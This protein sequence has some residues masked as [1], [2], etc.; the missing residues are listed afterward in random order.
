MPSNAW[1]GGAPPTLLLRIYRRTDWHVHRCVRLSAP[2]A[3]RTRHEEALAKTCAALDVLYAVAPRQ[4][5][6]LPDAVHS[7][8]VASVV[9]AA[10]C[11]RRDLRAILIDQGFALAPG[12]TPEDLAS[13]IV[14]ELAHAR[15]ERAGFEYVTS[16]RARIERICILAER[17]FVARL[18]ASRTRERLERRII[19][20][21]STRA[22]YW[23]DAAFEARK[24]AWKAR[25]PVWR[26]A[27]LDMLS[28]LHQAHGAALS[29]DRW[30]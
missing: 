17:N 20:G 1:L 7:I 22:D 8:T 3:R 21:L 15:L 25:Q 6:W 16:A 28:V 26:R 23:T 11:W 10:G 30:S 4:L 29:N 9:G 19:R 12:T 24:A 18:P 5:E 14:H 2:I 27:L 13:L